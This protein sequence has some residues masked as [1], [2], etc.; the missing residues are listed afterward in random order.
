MM[1]DPPGRLQFLDALDAQVAS[2]G[3]LVEGQAVPIVGFAELLD[4]PSHTP[5]RDGTWKHTRELRAVDLVGALVRSASLGKRDPGPWHDRADD[6]R[7]VA[8]AVIL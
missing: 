4:P 5:L 3:E 6:L 7:D 1:I 8:D 2:A